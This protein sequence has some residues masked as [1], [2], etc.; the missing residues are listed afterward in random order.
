MRAVTAAQ[1]R[2]LDRRAQEE[3]GIPE[4]LLM[5]HAGLAA[6]R[7]ARRHWKKK[8]RA[9][10]VLVLSGGG[11]NGGDGFVA[12]RHLDNWGIPVRV[13]LL[14]RSDRMAGAAGQNLQILLKL[15]L[16]LVEAASP[17][18]W[19]SWSRSAG[20]FSVII[21]ALLGTGASGEVREPIRSAIL[22][23]NRR[24]CPV[25]AVDLPSGLSADTG[26]P[27]GVAVR[28]TETVT[29]GLPK[30]GMTRTEGRRFSGRVHLA[31]IGL[32]RSL[33]S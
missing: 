16:P 20:R 25:I 1:M 22:W 3:F 9:S 23:I 27:C 26:I 14:A 19:E 4:L 15:K 6:A 31:D 28:A 11:A 5:E 32:P 13:V 17:S 29:C 10:E 2:R 8:R 33:R 7:S 18:L 21:D 24:R 30:V 12:A